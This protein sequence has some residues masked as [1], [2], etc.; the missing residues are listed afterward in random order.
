V[1]ERQII[2]RTGG[3]GKRRPETEVCPDRFER[4][5]QPIQIQ[6]HHFVVAESATQRRQRKMKEI[7]QQ[8]TY[9][10]PIQSAETVLASI[11]NFDDLRT[12]SDE[13]YRMWQSSTTRAVVQR[14]SGALPVPPCIVAGIL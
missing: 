1:I 7:R 2:E 11:A 4:A 5:C 8:Q 13:Q 12:H 6:I 3:P 9:A 10:D 14:I